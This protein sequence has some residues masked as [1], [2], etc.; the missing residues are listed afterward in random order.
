LK[1]QNIKFKV[2]KDRNKEYFEYIEKEKKEGE[3]YKA[4]SGEHSFINS[5]YPKEKVPLSHFIKNDDMRKSYYET[6]I[7]CRNFRKDNFAKLKELVELKNNEEFRVCT[8]GVHNKVSIYPIDKVPASLFLS[9]PSDPESKKYANCRDCINYASE[10]SRKNFEKKKKN[11]KEDEVLCSCSRI[12]K[13]KDMP[14]NDDDGEPSLTCPKCKEGNKI[15]RKKRKE[16]YSNLIYGEILKNNCSCVMCESVF[17]KPKEGTEYAITLNTYE[18]EGERFLE[19]EDKVYKVSD[20]LLK[21]RNLLE[22]L[23]L[24]FDHIPESE[25]D[26]V[27]EKKEGSVYNLGKKKRLKEIEKTQLLCC[28][29]HVIETI[30]REIENRGGKP[31]IKTPLERE[32]TK[33]INEVKKQGCSICGFYDK[34][35]LRFLE[36][37]HIDHEGKSGDVCHMKMRLCYS[38][39]DLINEIKKCR[40]LCR[41]CHKIH[42]AKQY[43]EGVKFKIKNKSN[44]DC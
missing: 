11:L 28:K 39:E 16:E 12:F 25:Y 44:E 36:F 37:D 27:Y 9:D 5:I 43:K 33:Y 13:K 17:L 32:K 21:N 10:M 8:T 34:N 31:Q 26:G 30:K 2:N 20:F 41:H 4:C 40:I 19:Y 14:I 42:T 38:L 22:F 23:I 6:C 7:D 15:T 1:D 29:C 18:K 3:K 24:E 35:L